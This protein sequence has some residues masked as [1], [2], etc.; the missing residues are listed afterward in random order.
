MIVIPLSYSLRNLFTRRLTTLLTVGGIALVVFV[1]TA[2]LMLAHGL[3][4]TLV[5]TGS[6]DNVIVVRKGAT[7][8]IMSL[9]DRDAV[10]II[11][12]QPEVAKDP[13]GR[14][15]AAAEAVALIHLSKR[16]SDRSSLILIRGV[17]PESLAMRRQVR[18][19]TGRFFTPGL[20]EVIVGA[21]M[22]QRFK[23]IGL[24]ERIHFAMRDWT[25]V[26]LFEAQE[27][28]FESEIW[29]DSEQTLQ[30]FRRPVYSSLTLRIA[31]PSAFSSLKNRLEADPRFTLEVKRE[32]H[33]YAD[34]SGILATFIR[35]LG[36]FVTLI[37]SLGAMIGAMITMYSAVANR[38]VEVGTLRALG[39]SR[40]SVLAAF[41]SESLLL[42]VIGGVTG[43]ILAS[44]LQA[45]TF[46]TMNFSSF[47]E[48]AFRFALSPVIA[49]ESLA[50]A[51]VMGLLGGFLPAVRA[52]RQNIVQSLRSA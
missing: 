33:Y 6:D 2:V 27:S 42:S 51:L 24:G 43:L 1:F 48:I 49:M 10:G 23:G 26:G 16:N 39:F 47:S 9:I 38:T 30:A 36:I 35:V 52:A 20:S 44:F 4:R 32:K 14:P 12:S 40:R 22:A 3:E 15:M 29:M 5:A 41:L 7:S 34:Q 28:G 37:F 31:D 50:F 45:V 13:E 46:S 11:K 25:V 8:E 21:R 17:S 18:L 19:T